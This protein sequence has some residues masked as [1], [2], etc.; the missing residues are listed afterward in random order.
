[1]IESGMKYLSEHLLFFG[2]LG[3]IFTTAVGVRAEIKRKKELR[4]AGMA[5]EADKYDTE[6]DIGI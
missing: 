1:M 2:L 3:L 5:A 4:S 6:N